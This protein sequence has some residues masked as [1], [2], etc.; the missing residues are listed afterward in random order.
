MK[1]VP[2]LLGVLATLAC[3]GGAPA[4]DRDGDLGYG[5]LRVSAQSPGQSLRLGLE[6]RAPSAVG[7]GD[8][9]VYVGDTW[10]NTWVDQRLY[11]LDFERMKVEAAV[12]RGVS[13]DWDVEAAAISQTTFGGAMDHSIATFHRIFGLG[14]NGRDQAPRGRTR[15]HIEPTGSQPGLDLDERDLQGVTEIFG[16]VSSWYTLVDG[17][18]VAPMVAVT[19]ALQM[20]LHHYT[21]YHGGY[22]DM[23]G[24]LSL[25]K[26][27]GWV[28][29]YAAGAYTRYGPD[30]LY[31]IRLY[32]GGFAGLGA[33]EV[34]ALPR[35]HLIAQYLVSQGIAPD[36]Y[37]FSK[38]SHELTVG[39]K[40]RLARRTE[41]E[42]ALLENL[43]IFDNSADFGLHLGLSTRW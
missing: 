43:F 25:A 18:R 26:R 9:E 27:F 11:Q 41:V 35:L 29:V 4:V 40:A 30:R 7:A 3:A 17:G 39:A 37:D 19:A 33:L 14:E 34:D 13:R 8:T 31:G 5:P 2:T 1:R 36:Y 21:R 42:L 10:T 16:R 15:I 24:G 38:A 22:V 28:H 6:P 32:Q 20:P 23:S 12:A